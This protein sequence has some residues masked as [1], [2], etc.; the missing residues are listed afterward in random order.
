VTA[1]RDASHTAAIGLTH[2][3]SVAPSRPSL[4]SRVGAQ[5]GAACMIALVLLWSLALALGAVAVI[6]L[7]WR[8]IV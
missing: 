5:V 7:S 6:V 3:L 8:A 4:A 1:Q 2:V